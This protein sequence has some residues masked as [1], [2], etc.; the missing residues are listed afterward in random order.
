VGDVAFQ[1][2]CLGKMENVAKEG[3]T[4]LFVSHNMAAISNLCS[5]GILLERGKI[6]L[7]GQTELVINKYLSGVRESSLISLQDRKDRQ[8][9]GKIRITGF[10]MFDKG[11]NKI[12]VLIS[13]QY[14]EF[15]IYYECINNRN[16]KNVNVGI[17]ISSHM[18]QFIALLSNKM[19]TS[20]FDFIEQEGY[21]SCKIGRL[22][23]APM[24]LSLNLIVRQNNIIQ[25]WIQEAVHVTVEAGDFY[26]TGLVTEESHGGFLIEQNWSAS[27]K[28]SVKVIR[29]SENE[30]NY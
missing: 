16:P 29:D 30:I 4:V 25:D 23:I 8:G 5:R 12:D 1:K 14:V 22:P 10:M 13:G 19:V 3:R 20:S 11:E 27:E 7:N 26:G 9:E 15:R 21:W 17:G 24:I 6:E 2:K 18:G 28:S